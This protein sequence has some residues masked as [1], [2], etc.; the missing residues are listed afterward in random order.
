MGLL[1]RRFDLVRC[2]AAVVAGQAMFESA[3]LSRQGAA[4]ATTTLTTVREEFKAPAVAGAV[5]RDG[6]VIAIGVSGVRALG[7]AGPVTLTDRWP[8]GSCSKPMARIVAARLADRG[9]WEL[10][11]TLGKLLP[12]VPMRADYKPVT[13]ANL[14]SHRG[15][16]QPYTQIGP[17]MTPIIFELQGS[18]VEQRAAF[19][20][21]LLD[22]EPAAP[23]GTRF[24][25]SNAG[26]CILAAA[27]EGRTGIPWE[28]LVKNEVFTPLGLSSAAV[29]ADPDPTNAVRGH[30]KSGGV[31]RLMPQG[32]QPLAVM[33]PAG[34]VCLSIEDFAKFAA[35]EVDL[36]AGRSAAGLSGKTIAQLPELRPADAG[37][38]ASA[39]E[40]FYGGDG[41]YTAAFAVWPEQRIAIVVASNAG[42][43]DAL[44]AAAIQALR[45]A[46]VPEAPTKASAGDGGPRFG[47]K[48]AATHGAAEWIIEGVD[49]GSIAERAGL[50]EGDAVVA[51]NG[52]SVETID[53]ESLAETVRSSKLVL[54]VEREGKRSEIE[55]KKP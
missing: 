51:I 48:L 9:V 54:T 36:D 18:P 28:T 5:V 10:G 4:D 12:D 39:G 22:E 16:I 11:D 41:F 23:P 45:S 35:A 49:P 1:R 50:K 38:R 32:R 3:A 46:Y 30:R 21:H 29:G 19:A 14:I 13:L 52:T 42:D 40:T 44:C 47:F 20:A 24:V 25:Y 26:F 6:K 15:G 27:A 55:L 53:P 2:A 8:I 37:P 43:S 31:Y 34:G 7:K 17:A 33:L